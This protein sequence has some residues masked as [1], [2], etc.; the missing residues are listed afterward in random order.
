MREH[1][2]TDD[3]GSVDIEA[4]REEVLQ[5]WA[6]SPRHSWIGLHD[7]MRARERGKVRSLDGVV[8]DA[9]GNEVPLVLKRLGVRDIMERIWPTPRVRHPFHGANRAQRRAAEAKARR[10]A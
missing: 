6:D 8:L 2:H 9:D 7:A 5:R 1:A 10:R 4:H 3:E